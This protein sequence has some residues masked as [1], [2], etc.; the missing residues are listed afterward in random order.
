[1]KQIAQHFKNKKDFE[2]PTWLIYL[3]GAIALVCLAFGVVQ[4]FRIWRYSRIIKASKIRI[5]E[6]DSKVQTAKFEGVKEVAKGQHKINK[7]E[8]KKIDKKIKEQKEKRKKLKKKIE[9][10][11]ASDLLKAFKEEGF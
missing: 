9:R 1:M 8:L 6:L 4:Q 7:E 10:M 3:F 5:T 2:L 11:E